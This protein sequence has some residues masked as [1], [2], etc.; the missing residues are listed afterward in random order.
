MSSIILY[1]LENPPTWIGGPGNLFLGYMST[2]GAAFTVAIEPSQPL[3]GYLIFTFLL[4]QAA[5]VHFPI[6]VIWISRTT[7]PSHCD[8]VLTCERDLSVKLQGSYRVNSSLSR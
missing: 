5:G 8:K 7:D 2:R 4:W 3:V 6:I 1:R